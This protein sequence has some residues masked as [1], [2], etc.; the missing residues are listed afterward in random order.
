M[1]LF[2]N[3]RKIIHLWKL[4]RRDFWTLVVSNYLFINK[5]IL[6]AYCHRT[7]TYLMAT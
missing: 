4:Q 7:I 5:S 2:I 1:D 6:K 3:F